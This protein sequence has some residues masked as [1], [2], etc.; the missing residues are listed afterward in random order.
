MIWIAFIVLALAI[1]PLAMTWKNLQLFQAASRDQDL[2]EKASTY[3]VSVLIP[4]RNEERSIERSLQSILSTKHP[5]IEVIVYDDASEDRTGDLVDAISR[6]DPRV[7]RIRGSGPPPGWNGKQ[8]ACWQA[9]QAS[10]HEVLVFVDADVRLTPDALTHCV[11]QWLAS[12]APLVSGFPRQETLTW[13]EQM[14]IPMMY[15]LL[16]GYL[17]ISQ[18]RSKKDPGFA[19]G[20]GQLFIAER[21][22]Y[23]A[24]G[25][26]QAIR[27]SRHDGIR[28]PRAYRLAQQAT[29]FFDASDMATCRMY[30]NCGEVVRGLLKNATEGMASLGLILPFSI[31]LAGANIF[32][33]LGMAAAMMWSDGWSLCVFALATLIGFV[34]RWLLAMHLPLSLWPAWIHPITV[35][36]FLS[37]QWIALVRA[38]LGKQVA[39]R[40]RRDS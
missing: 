9:A 27:E 38:M 37:L 28:L 26:H 22:T 17:P 18:M 34:P 1:L 16:L 23:F 15:T 7:R 20:C 12:K 21:T 24:V 2:L 11:A 3:R 35:A 39:W 40:G 8:H 4:A 13:S 32:P 30:L 14:L 6:T 29:D 5:D 19:A 31:L 33:L 36:W 10:Q 25:G